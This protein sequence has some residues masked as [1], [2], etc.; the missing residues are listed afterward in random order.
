MGLENQIWA[1]AL[2]TLCFHLF[3][4]SVPHSY[5]WKFIYS[6]WGLGSVVWHGLSMRNVFTV[7]KYAWERCVPH[8]CCLKNLENCFQYV[9]RGGPVVW[10][11]TRHLHV[12]DIFM[13]QTHEESGRQ[14]WQLLNLLLLIE[15]R[16]V[17]VFR[18][19]PFW[20]PSID[21]H[22]SS[23]LLKNFHD[24]HWEEYSCWVFPIIME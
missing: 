19:L 18:R 4:P 15:V 22:V 11:G 23:I 6:E 20:S 7:S 1:K 16:S 24:G 2:V 14:G 5:G 9:L 21:N 10:C 17:P 3:H 8:S 13:C 12:S